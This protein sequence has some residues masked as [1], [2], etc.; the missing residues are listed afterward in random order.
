MCK[1][2]KRFKY[3]KLDLNK[4]PDIEYFNLKILDL[5]NAGSAF[6]G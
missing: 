4:N 3:F 5:H 2:C 6:V 1:R